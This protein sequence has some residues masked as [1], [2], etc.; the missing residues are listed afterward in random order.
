LIRRYFLGVFRFAQMALADAGN[1]THTNNEDYRN[2][3][4]AQEGKRVDYRD[5]RDKPAMTKLETATSF[6]PL[7]PRNGWLNPAFRVGLT[8][9]ASTQN[10]S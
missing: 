6:A 9:G 4:L 10:Q 8:L 3:I 7:T 2:I 5:G 1:L